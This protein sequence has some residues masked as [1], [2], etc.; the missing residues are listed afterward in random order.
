MKSEGGGV[1]LQDADGVVGV[2]FR[3]ICCIGDEVVERAACDS[4]S[5]CYGM[6]QVFLC[7]E[8]RL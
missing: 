8:V 7:Q 2:K 4:G 1:G 6:L 3:D 5:L